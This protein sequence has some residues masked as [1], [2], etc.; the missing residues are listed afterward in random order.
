[1]AIVDATRARVTVNSKR[2]VFTWEEVTVFDDG[3]WTADTVT[4]IDIMEWDE[5]CVQVAGTFGGATVTIQGSADGINYVS[6]TDAHNGENLIFVEAGLK[7][8]AAP[9][10]RYIK[11]LVTPA[12]SIADLDVTVIAR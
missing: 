3:G 2:S 11:I 6:L 10:P 5:F 7:L 4:P 12:T 8:I 1:M 9:L